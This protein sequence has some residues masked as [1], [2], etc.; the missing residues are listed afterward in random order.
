MFSWRCLSNED[1]DDILCALLDETVVC[2]LKETLE[3]VSNN[4]NSSKIIIGQHQQQQ[5]QMYNNGNNNH[6][7]MMTMNNN[8]M[9]LK[10][11]LQKFFS[12]LRSR[13]QEHALPGHV[14]EMLK[15]IY[16]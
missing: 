11:H 16:I 5:R 7:K 6:N 2:R 3:I 15:R 4:D 9:M 8:A 12:K 10:N 14:E 1:R 13:I